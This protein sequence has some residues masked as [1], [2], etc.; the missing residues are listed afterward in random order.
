MLFK[1]YCVNLMHMLACLFNTKWTRN[2][3]QI[4]HDIWDQCYIDVRLTALG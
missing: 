4:L 1:V 2:E 3:S